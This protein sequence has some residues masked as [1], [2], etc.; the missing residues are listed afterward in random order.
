MPQALITSLKSWPFIGELGF[1]SFLMFVWGVSLFCLLM[2]Y[3]SGKCP[4]IGEQAPAIP[5]GLATHTFRRDSLWAKF[6]FYF[7]KSFPR[8]LCTY[9]W[10]SVVLG[11]SSVV[12]AITVLL[13][14]FLAATLLAMFVVGIFR[15]ALGAP[16]FL[17]GIL[18]FGATVWKVLTVVTVKFSSSA[19]N[20]PI[21]LQV[22]GSLIIFFLLILFF[23]SSAWK[24][25]RLR[26][27]AFK[28]KNCPLIRFE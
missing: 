17:M 24:I 19:Y 1:I 21:V 27:K 3:V 13:C 12:G 25:T 28:E 11:I 15:L 26:W 8:D 16:S 22:L 9:F 2:I 6:Y 14:L 23:R 5:T 7:Y 10:Q 18:V 4:K 20:Q